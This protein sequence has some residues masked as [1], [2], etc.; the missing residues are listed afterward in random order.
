[1]IVNVHDEESI[2]TSWAADPI[3]V[4]YFHE[5]MSLFVHLRPLV[6]P[7]HLRVSTV[8]LK[9]IPSYLSSTQTS[10]LPL[11]HYIYRAAG[12]ILALL[13]SICTQAS[14]GLPI[15]RRA[16]YPTPHT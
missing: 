2:E 13:F 7:D 10:V 12:L 9:R 15:F 11:H 8:T 5:M 4:P 14:A 3:E 16:S 6:K 1:M